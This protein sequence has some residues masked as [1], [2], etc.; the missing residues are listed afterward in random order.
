MNKKHVYVGGDVSTTHSSVSVLDSNG[1]HL[2]SFF[3]HPTESLA[4]N[5]RKIVGKHLHKNIIGS[6]RLAEHLKFY[7]MIE[8]IN[9]D[10][11]GSLIE[12]CGVEAI[13]LQSR[14]D[15]VSLAMSQ[16]I[17]QSVF[18]ST[19]S[20]VVEIQP[21]SVKL[22]MTGSGGSEK[23]EVCEAVK[24]S[25]KVDPFQRMKLD[26]S[27]K[28]QREL[29]YDITDSI[30]IAEFVRAVSLYREAYSKDPELDASSLDVIRAVL[31]ITKGAYR[32]CDKKQ[33]KAI[34]NSMKKVLVNNVLLV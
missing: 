1:N 26:N 11:S 18:A 14:G 27:V 22:F 34:E 19:G 28:V 9:R 2:E 25:F 15:I 33:K 32:H 23:A 5:S 31:E 13:S 3:M 24:L 21:S 16:G 29:A 6:E 12:M 7:Q 4:K 30:A 17:Y 20:K 8:E 10:K